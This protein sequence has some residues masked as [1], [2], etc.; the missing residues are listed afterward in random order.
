MSLVCVKFPLSSSCFQDKIVTPQ[1]PS[2]PLWATVPNLGSTL[3]PISVLQP[4]MNFLQFFKCK[5]PRPILRSKDP[6]M[7]THPAPLPV[8]SPP[9]LHDSSFFSQLVGS[10]STL[11]IS[12]ILKENP[13]NPPDQIKPMLGALWKSVPTGQ[14]LTS[15]VVTH[16]NTACLSHTSSTRT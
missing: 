2:H 13:L 6:R 4:Q 14:H 10:H 3:P 5:M 11:K 8:A 7:F 1:G 15:K 9:R 16:L 12:F